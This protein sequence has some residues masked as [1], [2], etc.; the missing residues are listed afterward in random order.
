M[1]NKQGTSYHLVDELWYWLR[2][3]NEF[4]HQDSQSE[5]RWSCPIKLVY[6]IK[7]VTKLFKV[8][9]V[10]WYLILWCTRS[11]ELTVAILLWC[12]LLDLRIIVDLHLIFVIVLKMVNKHNRR[13][14]TSGLGLHVGTNGFKL[15]A[16]SSSVLVGLVLL[17]LLVLL[18][19]LFSELL[20]L[21]SLR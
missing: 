8:A 12:I 11:S 16:S 9:H 21:L 20:L 7:L 1:Y 19:Q 10:V 2:P 15:V 4:H 13:I 18:L 5:P 6:M 3:V 14:E 17:K